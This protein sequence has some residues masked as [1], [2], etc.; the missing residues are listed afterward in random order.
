MSDARPISS[1]LWVG[2]GQGQSCGKAGAVLGWPGLY[3]GGA[4]AVAV[5]SSAQK[6]LVQSILCDPKSIRLPTYLPR[7]T[8]LSTYL[9]TDTLS[10]GVMPI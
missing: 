3:Y 10:H 6:S 1:R 2:A 8:Y 9:L 4:G 5:L 7:P